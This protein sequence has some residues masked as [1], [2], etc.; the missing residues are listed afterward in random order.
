MSAPD[1]NCRT[2]GGTGK[3]YPEHLAG[4]MVALDTVPGYDPR[5]PCTCTKRE[6][7]LTHYEMADRSGL[8]PGCICGWHS[9]NHE[10]AEFEGHLRSV[11]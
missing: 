9:P 7:A 3:A 10:H 1:P 11:T 6:H 4:G 5:V 2:C 8:T